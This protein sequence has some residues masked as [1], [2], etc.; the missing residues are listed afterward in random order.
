MI[1]QEKGDG[2]FIMMFLMYDSQ[3]N[4]AYSAPITSESAGGEIYTGVE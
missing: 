3:G 2:L 4:M 1:K